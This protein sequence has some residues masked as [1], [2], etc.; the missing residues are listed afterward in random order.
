MSFSSSAW[1]LAMIF[2]RAASPGVA[3]L[4]AK[5]LYFFPIAAPSA[6]LLFGL[7]YSSKKVNKLL[8]SVI[9]STAFLI[10]IV[11][12]IKGAVIVEV[13]PSATGEKHII[14]GWA[15]YSLYL[16][17]YPMVFGFAYILFLTKSLAAA[18]TKKAQLFSLLIGM[19]ATSTLAMV[20]NLFLPTLGNF[21]FNW[22]GQ[23]C[24]FFWISSTYLAIQ[25]YHLLDIRRL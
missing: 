8:V 17:Y 19:G 1:C 20:T 6:F 13:I 15:Y 16:L 24:V 18:R 3:T 25:K 10:A 12:L 4:A 11:T 14:F 5:L 7:F 9:I 23:V 21:Q 2:Y 22:V